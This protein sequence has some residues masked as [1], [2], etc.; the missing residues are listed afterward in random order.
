MFT[1]IEDVKD[2]F[3]VSETELREILGLKYW[4]VRQLRESGV[5]RPAAKINRRYYYR[6][7]E[8]RAKI[9]GD[10]PKA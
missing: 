10:L 9:L 8:V 2:P 1:Q 7:N 5:I 3:L 4:T 6:P